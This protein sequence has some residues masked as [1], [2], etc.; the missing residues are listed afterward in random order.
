MSYQKTIELM[1]SMRL[2]GMQTALE[3]IVQGK[4]VTS[5]SSEQLLSLLMQQEWDDRN[6]RKIQ[7]L[8]RSA[9]FRYTSSL[10]EIS[11]DPK[12]NLSACQNQ[13]LCMG[14][15]IRKPDHHRSYRCW[16]KSFSISHWPSMLSDG[17]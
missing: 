6:N 15:E 16:Q 8:T 7:R 5:L 3:G 17:V 2:Y 14:G 11:P 12:R 13:H 10:A 9:R 4:K 1:Q